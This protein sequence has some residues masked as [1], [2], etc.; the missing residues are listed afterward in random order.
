MMQPEWWAHRAPVS[1]VVQA[2]RHHQASQ[3]LRRHA[4]G[5]AAR[6]VALGRVR[7]CLHAWRRLSV[8]HEERLLP[9]VQALLR[10]ALLARC[11]REWRR[12]C[13]LRW[14]KLQ[15]E[16][17][18]AQL[19]KLGAQ[20]SSWDGIEGRARGGLRCPC[21]A[22]SSQLSAPRVVQYTWPCSPG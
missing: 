17:R 12:V 9:R 22:T 7:R 19:Q 20:A 18:D 11:W 6:Q 3:Q 4:A 16:L 14:W 15:L 8:R 21:R 10:R 5:A 13:G 1:V 2:W